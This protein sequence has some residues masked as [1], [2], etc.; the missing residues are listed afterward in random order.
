LATGWAVRVWPSFAVPLVV[1]D[2][3][4]VTPLTVMVAV[5]LAVTLVLPPTDASSVVEEAKVSVSVPSNSL[6]GA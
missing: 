3:V 5:V 1:T 2:S 4:G 6:F